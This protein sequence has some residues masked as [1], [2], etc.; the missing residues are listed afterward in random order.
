MPPP[1]QIPE[2]IQHRAN[3]GRKSLDDACKKYFPFSDL[4]YWSGFTCQGLR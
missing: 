1:R 3:D 4:Y 2:E